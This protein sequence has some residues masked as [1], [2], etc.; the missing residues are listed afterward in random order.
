M[1]ESLKSAVQERFATQ[2]RNNEKTRTPLPTID[3][4]SQMLIVSQWSVIDSEQM[5]EQRALGL[6]EPNYS[7]G[8][9]LSSI[10][11]LILT[12]LTL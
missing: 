12:R 3:N 7:L 10:F 4:F 9:I 11:S 8:V 5:C 1:Q 6:F 2:A